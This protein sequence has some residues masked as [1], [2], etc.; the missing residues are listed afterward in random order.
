MPPVTNDPGRSDAM[1]TLRTL[2]GAAL[3]LAAGSVF[4]GADA[5]AQTQAWISTWAAPATARLDQPAQTLSPAAQAFPW[6]TD[7]PAAV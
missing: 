3:L 4:T 2:A 7:V 6:S 5:Q 1:T